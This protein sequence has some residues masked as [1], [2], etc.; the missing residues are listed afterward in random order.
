M[1]LS[2]IGY[3]SASFL[4]T[5]DKCN[6]IYDRTLQMKWSGGHDVML[7]SEIMLFE[8]CKYKAGSRKRGQCLDRVAES[9]SQLKKQC[10][11]M[12]Q[13]SVRDRLKILERDFKK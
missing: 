11:S 7:G 9:L 8:L 12:S 1:F 3:Y 6:S 5:S 13:K 10:F 4:L 2:D